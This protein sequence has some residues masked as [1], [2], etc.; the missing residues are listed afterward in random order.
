MTQPTSRKNDKMGEEIYQI[1]FD[2]IKIKYKNSNLSKEDNEIKKA[3][4]MLNIIEGLWKHL[5]EMSKRQ[6]KHQKFN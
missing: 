3:I 5:I 4:F 2:N 1:L 6:E